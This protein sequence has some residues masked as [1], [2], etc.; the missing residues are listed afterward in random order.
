MIASIA[1]A[2]FPVCLSPII[3]SLCPLPIG[4]P[5]LESLPESVKLTER[6]HRQVFDCMHR[7]FNDVGMV[8]ESIQHHPHQEVYQVRTPEDVVGTVQTWYRPT[9]RWITALEFN[10]IPEAYETRIRGFPWAELS[11]ETETTPVSSKI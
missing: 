7:V 3:S 5:L 6:I 4:E 8:V 11:P 10:C 1:T 2:V 9:T